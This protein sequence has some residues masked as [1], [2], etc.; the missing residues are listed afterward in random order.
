MSFTGKRGEN[1]VVVML[2]EE[3]MEKAFE[4]YADGTNGIEL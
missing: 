3:A 2:K 1:G 4:P